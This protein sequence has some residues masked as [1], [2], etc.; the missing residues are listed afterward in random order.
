MIRGAREALERSGAA[1]GFGDW[2]DRDFT[3]CRLMG[4]VSDPWLMSGRAV[5][6][7]SG[8]H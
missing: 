5:G 1:T 4:L 6:A 3:P 7:D 2:L 8:P